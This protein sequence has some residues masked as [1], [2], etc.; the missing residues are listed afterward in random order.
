[1]AKALFLVCIALGIVCQSLAIVSWYELQVLLV[2]I[3]VLLLA[4]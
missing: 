2:V 1:M 3:I 4:L